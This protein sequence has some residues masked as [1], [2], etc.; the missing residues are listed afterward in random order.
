[1]F[2]KLTLRV[3]DKQV[4]SI[5]ANAIT[6]GSEVLSCEVD[7]NTTA[8]ARKPRSSPAPVLVNG[9]KVAPGLE[10]FVMNQLTDGLPHSIQQLEEDFKMHGKSPSSVSPT[11]S[12]LVKKRL[13]LRTPDQNYVHLWR[14]TMEAPK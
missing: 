2:Y 13:V 3:S 5:I 8:P 9:T 11:L 6:A 10:Q 1:M 12:K 7:T 4:A 14:H